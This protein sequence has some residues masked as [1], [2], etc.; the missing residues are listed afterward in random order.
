MT[1][2]VENL[3]MSVN[4]TAIREMSGISLEIIV[5]ELSWKESS[6]GKLPNSVGTTA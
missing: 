3:E 4:F 5:M 6:Q 2:S 1:T